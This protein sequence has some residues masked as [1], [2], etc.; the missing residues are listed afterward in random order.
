L[1]DRSLAQRI[2]EA[3]RWRKT[4]WFSSKLR[5]SPLRGWQAKEYAIALDMAKDFRAKLREIRSPK[6]GSVNRASRARAS[7][8]SWAIDDQAAKRRR[9]LSRCSRALAHANDK[10]RPKLQ[11]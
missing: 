8:L 9:A 6:L 5:E 1:R 10:Q 4:S 3:I 7:S 2:G 11:P